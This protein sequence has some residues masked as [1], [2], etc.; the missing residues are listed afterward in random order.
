MK[1]I[2]LSA[3]L[4]MV[5]IALFSMDTVQEKSQTDE[6]PKLAMSIFA[7]QVTDLANAL[8][9]REYQASFDDDNGNRIEVSQEV[10]KKLN[11]LM[12]LSIV[13]YASESEEPLDTKVISPNRYNQDGQFDKTQAFPGIEKFTLSQDKKKVLGHL[14]M[15]GRYFVLVDLEQDTFTK[16]SLN[17]Q[18]IGGESLWMLPKEFESQIKAPR[19][20]LIEIGVV[21]AVGK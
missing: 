6:D 3:S 1:K 19:R 5:N 9:T 8:D 17:Y 16:Y 7:Q 12:S 11:R 13:R 10:D 15:D 4:L 21:K 18:M 2:V 14:S 20:S